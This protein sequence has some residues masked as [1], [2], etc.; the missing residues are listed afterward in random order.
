MKKIA[1]LICTIL[2]SL[3]GF[4][5]RHADLS[6]AMSSPNSATTVNG[7][8]SFAFS[9]TITNNG[10][11]VLKTTDTLVIAFTIDNKSSTENIIVNGTNYPQLATLLSGQLASGASA[12]ISNVNMS[13]ANFPGAGTHHLCAVAVMLNRSA[14][15]VTDAS[16]N[17]N[18]ACADVV[19]KNPTSVLGVA[20]NTSLTV[21]PNPA[22][23]E[24]N[25]S[26][27]I[28]SSETAILQIIDIYGRKVYAANQ[29]LQPGDSNIKVNTSGFAGGTYYYSMQIGEH[30]EF[31]KL[32]IR[33]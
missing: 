21:F 18:K 16:T 9:A 24:V 25:F 22:T 13:L 10:P 27:R 28:S 4:A 3:H 11:D 6:I 15:S 23:T 26:L 1:L 17:N 33:K 29:I 7:N 20:T 31:G 30:Q 14:D 8:D 32:V 19:F 12:T 2:F 5:Q